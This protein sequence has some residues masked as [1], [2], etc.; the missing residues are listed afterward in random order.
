MSGYD[1]EGPLLN[2]RLEM[3]G[4]F[5]KSANG[6]GWMGLD[7]EPE[8]DELSLVDQQ[9]QWAEPLVDKRGHEP[10]TADQAERMGSA[11]GERTVDGWAEADQTESDWAD[12]GRTDG[13]RTETGWAGTGRTKATRIG[14]GWT[15]MGRPE[16]GRTGHRPSPSN[17]QPRRVDS[18]GPAGWEGLVWGTPRSWRVPGPTRWL[19]G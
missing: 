10:E 8:D 14:P 7:D 18:K 3:V 13:G 2:V 19:P 6:L 4:H 17:Q 12:T 5:A 15:G 16:V 1:T 11:P 9:A